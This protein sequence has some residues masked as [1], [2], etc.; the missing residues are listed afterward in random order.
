VKMKF[1]TILQAVLY[2]AAVLAASAGAGQDSPDAAIKDIQESV[3]AMEPHDLDEGVYGLDDLT[4]I[5]EANIDQL[6]QAISVENAG[7]TTRHQLDGLQ[8]ILAQSILAFKTGDMTAI[9]ADRL[10]APHDI[11][12]EAANAHRSLV[13]SAMLRDGESLPNTPE[14]VMRLLVDRRYRGNQGSGYRDLY[15]E[16]SVQGSSIELHVV[17]ALPV[18]MYEHLK[19]LV[20]AGARTARNG[21]I[22]FKPSIQY[23][24]SPQSVLQVQGSLTYA[25][26]W[27]AASDA[28]DHRYRRFRRYYWSPNDDTWLP[29]EMFS[30]YVKTRRADV[31]F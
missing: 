1:T 18:R 30:L 12:P 2:G 3:P 5:T 16:L 19:L 23:H 8:Q 26:V 28:D 17:N 21:I 20:R 25:D 14:Q 15:N 7:D 13:Q 22:S 10:R 9:L 29:M 4:E 27:L 11:R 24:N 6:V 31:F